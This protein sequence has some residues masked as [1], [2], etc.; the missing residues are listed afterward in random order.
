VIC[1]ENNHF[2][3]T[4]LQE[5]YMKNILDF[6]RQDLALWFEDNG[7]RGFRAGQIFK[8]LYIKQADSFEQMTYISKSLRTTL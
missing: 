2:Q 1:Q 8:W 6:T 3:H 5:K 7:I 4:N